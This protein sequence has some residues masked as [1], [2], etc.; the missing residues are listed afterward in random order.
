MNQNKIS[1]TIS[2][3]ELAEAAK[4]L[5]E[6]QTLLMPYLIALSPDERQTIIKMGDK[7]SAFVEKALEYAVNKPTLTPGFI[8]L[9]EWQIDSRAQG[10]LV[11]L[12]R[13]VQQLGSN[14]DD[15]AM[16][17]G[18]ESYASALGFYHNVKQAS[19]MNVPD[20]KSIFE[21]LSQRF[22]GRKFNRAKPT[23][24]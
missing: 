8:E 14:L 1:V 6:V 13:M 20:A 16:L 11:K 21:D 17:C 3:G 2:D 19:K 15:T 7:T 4:K 22:P 12:L 24:D 18:S 5:N 9:P 23:L 10:S